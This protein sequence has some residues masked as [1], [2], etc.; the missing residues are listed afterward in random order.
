MLKIVEQLVQEYGHEI[1]DNRRYLHAH[2]EL[3]FH[4]TNTAAWVRERLQKAGIPTLDG[5]SGNSTVG[6]LKGTQPGPSI[7]LRSDMD[8]LGL[9]ED[10]DLPFK[11]TNPG[12]MH[13]CGHD[14][15]TAT[16]MAVAEL[17]AKHQDLIKGTVYFIFEQGEEFLPGGAVQLVKDGIMKKIDYIFAIHVDALHPVGTIDVYEGVRFAAVGTFDFKITGKGGHGGFPHKANNPLIPASELIKDISLIPALKCDPL[18]SATVSVTYLHCGVE[19]VANVIPE[20]VSMGGC[21][22]VLDTALRQDIMEEIERLGKTI[23]AA[24]QCDI[25]ISM[26]YGYPACVVNP[27]CAAVMQDAAKDMGIKVLDVPPN[28][29][30]EDFG[31]FSQEKPT[32]IGWF[33]IADPTGKHAPTPHHSPQFYIDDEA[34]LPKA[35]AYMLTVYLKV[36]ERFQ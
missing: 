25:D 12:V 2:P 16:L 13:G 14:A 35:L 22:R 31:Y 23:C 19:G 4:E 7:G 5:I 36:V 21:I 27:V 33:G 20:K 32:A 11:S 34:G 8:A 29:G 18:Q 17:L 26:V 28:L 30:A 24:H 10:N 1:V 3:S 9:T 6:Y 15:H